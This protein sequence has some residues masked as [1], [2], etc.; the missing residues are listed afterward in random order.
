MISKRL[1]I[2][3]TLAAAAMVS[4]VLV[5]CGGSS[6]SV[7]GINVSVPVT[8]GVQNQGG[9][10]T[11]NV[12]SSTSPQQVQITAADG[13][14]QTVVVP[15]GE[16]FS[17]G[18]Q[19]VVLEPN[20]PVLNG[21][22]VGP[23]HNGTVKPLGTGGHPIF[24]DGLNSG[25]LLNAGGALVT[26]ILLGVGNHTILVDGPMTITGT[27]STGTPSTL[28]IN[29]S[30]TIKVQVK[31]VGGL[32]FASLPIDIT[33]KLPG[34]GGST[35]NGNSVTGDLAG[36]TV[37]YGQLVLTWPGV[38]K[39]QTVPIRPKGN[40]GFGTFTFHDPLNDS[41]DTIPSTGIDTI[42]FT[43]LPNI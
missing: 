17:A 8:G 4:G 37:G 22:T 13:T 1:G 6:A 7:Q 31:V 23:V 21:L 12:S 14:T 25:V 33:G 35:A 20:Q 24:I 5:G 28:S 29:T 38:T 27:S 32:P 3:G 18:D 26:G 40:T 19:A 2:I 42:A 15:P 11:T 30:V 16:S 39:S 10:P 41:T 36:F 34:N 9:S 43:F